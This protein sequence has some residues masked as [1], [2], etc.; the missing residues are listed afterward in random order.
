[1]SLSAWS[2]R[3]SAHRSDQGSILVFSF[4]TDFICAVFP[5]YL[6]RN[7]NIRRQSYIAL[8]LLM[9]LGVVT[10]AIAV[11]RTA[12]TYQI[13]SPDLPWDSI[14]NSL[15]R[16]FEVNIGNV[17][18]CA[19]ILRPF[20]RYVLAKITGRDPH[21]ILRRRSS[22][23]QFHIRWYR[24]AWP[25]N[26]R[27]AGGKDETNA[28]DRIDLPPGVRNAGS[29]S[30]N[31]H[32]TRTETSETASIALPIQGTRGTRDAIGIPE[33]PDKPDAHHFRLLSPIPRTDF[34]SCYEIK[35][36]V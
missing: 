36:A 32:S 6:L 30:M 33:V 28:R 14:P 10:G 5:I 3:G 34:R 18:A 16:V 17:A 7:L 2:S 11:A 26:V 23:S 15:T 22:N 24:R 29:D 35:D 13:S 19:P 21:Q 25:S 1:M 20:M 4:L 8:C 31:E 12:T 9:G 27:G